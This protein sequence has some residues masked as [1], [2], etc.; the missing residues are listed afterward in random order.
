M[1]NFPSSL[2]RHMR[3]FKALPSG[4]PFRIWPITLK[5]AVEK[6]NLNGAASRES[7]LQDITAANQTCC[8]SGEQSEPCS[9][10][11]EV[12]FAL[13]IDVNGFDYAALSAGASLHVSHK[14]YGG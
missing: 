13:L 9:L 7:V 12:D 3:I 4:N 6:W 8:P 14:A 5:R 2:L 10:I 1:S 11:F